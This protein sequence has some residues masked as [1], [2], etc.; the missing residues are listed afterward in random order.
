MAVKDMKGFGAIAVIGLVA[1][2]L[3]KRK[4]AAAVSPLPIESL[5]SPLLFPMTE[6]PR[7]IL[8]LEP[9]TVIPQAVY[10]S[11]PAE[12]VAVLQTTLGVAQALPEIAPPM[13]ERTKVRIISAPKMRNPDGS[14]VI[15][16]TYEISI[17]SCP[18]VLITAIGAFVNYVQKVG[19]G[20]IGTHTLELYFPA[21][22]PTVG[23]WIDATQLIH[24]EY[25]D[26]A[27][28]THEQWRY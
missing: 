14:G 21:P 19:S 22:P 7:E 6:I 4:P 16:V 25:F 10:Q 2:A 18:T 15:P 26:G 8:L 28:I 12:L 9:V 1:W 5:A 27:V 20:N 13:E 3:L 17:K 11:A 23:A 24:L